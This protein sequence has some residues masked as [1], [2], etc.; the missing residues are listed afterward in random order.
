MNRPHRIFRLKIGTTYSATRQPDPCIA[1]RILEALGT[2]ASSRKERVMLHLSEAISG[3]TRPAGIVF[4]ALTALAAV[5]L[6]LSPALAR[7]YRIDP[8]G[9]GDAATIQAA[10]TM[11]AP[12]DTVLLANGVYRGP[13]NRDITFERNSVTL[14]SISDN[15][16]SCVI[17]C[18]LQGRGFLVDA[19][20]PHINGITITNGHADTGGAA[21]CLRHCDPVFS[22]CT[23]RGNRADED[24]GAVRCAEIAGGDFVN[25]VFAGNSATEGGG[26]VALCCCSVLRFENC[27][28]VDN[29]S[30]EGTAFNC[31][32]LS[33]LTLKRSIIAFHR[34]ATP[35]GCPGHCDARIDSCDVFGNEGGDWVGCADSLANKN[36]NVSVDPGLEDVQARDFRLRENSPLRP[37]DRYSKGIGA[38]R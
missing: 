10:V 16:D 2:P 26:A 17:D 22:N 33:G 25:C 5:A 20:A 36:G 21:Y 6:V 13:G 19:A 4:L 8:H 29:E 12:V 31:R 38:V 11:A 24:G 30:K 15:P 14:S 34:G 23:F 28:V 7:T 32:G 18:E 27:T 9:Q 35:I 37:A 3:T 1:A